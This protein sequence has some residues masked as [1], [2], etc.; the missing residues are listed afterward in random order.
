MGEIF[1]RKLILFDTDL[2]ISIIFE[3]GFTKFRF[4]QKSIVDPFETPLD[5]SF[6]KL[7]A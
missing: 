7:W 3:L 5:A 6:F 1:V 4:V 2:F